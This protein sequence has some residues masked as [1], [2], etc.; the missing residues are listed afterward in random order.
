MNKYKLSIFDAKLTA[1][2]GGQM[3]AYVGHSGRHLPSDRLKKL[4]LNEEISGCNEKQTYLDFAE[5]V[6]EIKKINLEFLWN[7]KKM[8]KLIVGMGA[9]VK[10]NTLL[11]YFGIKSDLIK[12]LL[13]KNKMRKGLYAP[14]SHIPIVL[15]DELDEKADIYYVL[16]WNFKREI[17]KN[18][19]TLIKSGRKFYFPIDIGY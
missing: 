4:L 13:E 18:N 15:E 2:H 16:A 12:V 10:G 3:I 1:T 9:P 14:G 11:N 17:L 5:R 7:E 19:E 8:G 6:K